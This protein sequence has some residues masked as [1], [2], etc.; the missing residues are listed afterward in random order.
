MTVRRLPLAVGALAMLAG[1]VLAVTGE[2]TLSPGSR[3][4]PFALAVLVGGTVAALSVLV[5]STEGPETEPLPEPGSSANARI[6]GER[7]DQRLAGASW[8]EGE[9]RAALADRIER[10]AV[11]TLARTERWTPAEARERLRDGTWTDDERAAALLSDGDDP[12]SVGDHVRALATGESPFQ[13]RAD[14]AMAELHD[15]VDDG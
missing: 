13:R 2:P 15:R 6:P 1:G 10:T 5:R 4:L 11:T 3:T 7:V 8:R 12:P 9:T 14:R